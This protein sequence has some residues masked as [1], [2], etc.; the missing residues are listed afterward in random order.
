M[1]VCLLP[2]P[3]QLYLEISVVFG[4]SICTATTNSYTV[5]NENV[6]LGLFWGEDGVG[7]HSNKKVVL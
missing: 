3:F 2:Y 7:K 1:S 5:G 6:V 4:L